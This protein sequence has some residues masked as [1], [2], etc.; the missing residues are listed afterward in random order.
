I[1][2]A[3]FRTDNYDARQTVDAVY[4]MLDAEPVEGL[5][6]SGGARVERTLQSVSPKDLWPTGLGAVGGARVRSTDV[7][8][9][10]NATLALGESMNVR[11][12]ASRTLARAELRELAPFSFAD[13]AGGFLVIGNPRLERARITNLDLRWE[14][15]PDARSVLAVSGF[16]KRFARPIEVSVLPSSE[17]I[18]TWVNAGEADNRGVEI[19]ARSGLG[20]LGDALAPLEV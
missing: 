8:P 13:Y 10:L 19:E 12:G 1:R 11:A 9:A 5:R 18:K 15:F 16:Y 17:L 4:A 6:L 3:T 20:V 2:E 14:W 7:L